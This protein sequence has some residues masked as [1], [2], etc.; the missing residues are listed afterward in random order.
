M[1]KAE[2]LAL[3]LLGQ[4]WTQERLRNL[5]KKKETTI[6]KLK[7]SISLYLL[8]FTAFKRDE[9]LH[10]REDLYGYDTILSKV[11]FSSGGKK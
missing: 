9:Q 6:L 8:Y 10:F 3:Y 4:E 1:E 11:L 7:E 5:I 2:D